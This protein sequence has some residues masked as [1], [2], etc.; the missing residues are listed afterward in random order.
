VLSGKSASICACKL[1]L[2]RG[3][4]SSLSTTLLLLLGFI[5]LAAVSR[6]LECEK[7]KGS[8]Q[9]TKSVF[10]LVRGILRRSARFR[11]FG[12][13]LIK[14]TPLEIRARRAVAS[15]GVKS[16]LTILN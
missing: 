10:R 1:R 4:T 11:G 12:H 2:W 15:T 14:T 5:A 13:N 8:P 9:L 7:E 16:I 3:A 6:E